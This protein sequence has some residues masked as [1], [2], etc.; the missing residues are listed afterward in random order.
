MKA[1]WTLGGAP[2]ASAAHASMIVAPASASAE[3]CRR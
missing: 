3:A 2:D 1:T